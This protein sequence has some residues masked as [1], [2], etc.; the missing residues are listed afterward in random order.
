MPSW[1]DHVRPR[2]A[3][4]QL[5]P[6]REAEIV[7]ELSQHLDQ[8]F[9]ELLAKGQSVEEA[10]RL[11][12]EELLEPDALANHM[13]TLRQAHVPPPIAPG[14]PQSSLIRDLGQD[15][16]YAVR[17][18]RKQPAFAM[19]AILTLALGIGVNSAIFALVD[20]TLLRPLPYP[21]GDRLVMLSETTSTSRSNVSPV[22][23]ADWNDR[24]RT[25]EAF[26]G[27][28]PNVG[29]MV[30]TGA[31]GNAETVPRQWVSS[32]L[33]D[34]LGVKA[35]A[36]RTFLP[37][38]DAKRAN[39]VVLSEGFWRTRFNAD[40]SVVG[41]DIRLDGTPFTVVGIVPKDFQLLSPSSMWAMR[42]IPRVPQARRAYIWTAVGR[43]KPGVTVEAARADLSA[44]A[45]G[46]ARE[47]PETN[48][49]RGVA[50]E[51]LHDA[52]IG[53]DLRLTSM[54]FLGVVGVVLLMCC[55]N[56]ANLLL[57]RAT[58]RARELAVRSALGA[59]RRRVIQQL[60]TES[61]L[62]SCVG[63]IV[64]GG[65][66]AIILRAAPSVIPD[67]LLPAAVTITFDIRV[68]AFCVVTALLV[69]LLFGLA[70]AWHATGFAS[71]RVMAS[72]S[73]AV[74]GRGGG[75]RG[76]L[77]VAEVS[78]AV[79]LLFGAGLLLRTLLAV[80][81]VDRG[82]K[83]DR[84]LTMMV[85]PLGSSYPTPEALLR[86]F[87]SIEREIRSTPTV[88]DVAWASTL[89]LGESEPVLFEIVGDAPLDE[90]ERPTADYQII[91][92]SYFKTIDLPIVVGRAF[93]DRDAQKTTAVC[94]VSESF[95]RHYL[96]GRSPIGMR[97]GMRPAGSPQTPPIV[98]EIVGVARTVKGR[99]DELQDR[100]QLYVPLAQ[101]PLDDMYVLVRPSVGDAESLVPSVRA[102]IGRIDKEQLVSVRD[103]MTL[104]DVAS[105]ATARHRFRAV[106]VSG[107]AGL[108]MLLAMVGVFGILAYAVQQHARDFGVRRALGATTGDVLR[109]VAGSASRVIGTGVVIGLVL[110]TIWGRLLAT[111]L[112]GVQPLDPMTFASV[113]IV[114]VLT[115]ALSAAAPA[116][117][118]TRIDPMDALR[119]D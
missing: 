74:I 113:L 82:Y 6:A 110:S 76:L 93:D 79:L 97:V 102:A 47:F 78:T 56:V 87:D 11:A 94:I 72:D 43:M 119:A 50:V 116:W 107:F 52:L 55:A 69:G 34:A 1:N 19:T 101:R 14:A 73:R 33:F 44:V 108:A 53:S 4:L 71:S 59:S 23:M 62:L 83:A 16:R 3:R 77:V 85:D 48:K 64:G 51:S 112:F 25:F 96:Q 18:L 86:F 20:A 58:S 49:G 45:D 95:V 30:M 106:L 60:L 26:G 65:L 27:F 90:H 37:S 31:D 117:R 109:H 80:E 104:D 42:T 105:V 103:V 12:I 114:V 57:A 100:I 24:S 10:S 98:R 111:M 70:P 67:G 8:R 99:P 40:P 115:A 66:G 29:G 88:G 61:L 92:S 81:T 84:V 118:A 39:A 22:N 38:D 41:R 46:L 68:I 5:S 89:P 75:I 15:V 54:L 28:A 35:I 7:E 91:S 21:A 9:E 63:A 32:G 36:G 13:R 17:T 2:L